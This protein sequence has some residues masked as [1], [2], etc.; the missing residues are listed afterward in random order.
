MH[1]LYRRIAC[2]L[3]KAFGVLTRNFSSEL[4]NGVT[5]EGRAPARPQKFFGDTET[6]PIQLFTVAFV[7]H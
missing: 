1:G 4:P 3:A 2:L 6:R 5:L 7:I